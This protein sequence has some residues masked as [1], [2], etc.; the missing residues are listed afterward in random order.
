MVPPETP[1]TTSAA[2]IAIPLRK[3][4]KYFLLN[5]GVIEKI[6]T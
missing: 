6:K 5:D 3:V 1:G 2:P 4:E